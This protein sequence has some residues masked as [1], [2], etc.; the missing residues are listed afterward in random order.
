MLSRV[1]ALWLL[2]KSLDAHKEEVRTR[3]IDSTWLQHIQIRELKKNMYNISKQEFNHLKQLSERDDESHGVYRKDMWST[4][5]SHQQ[6]PVV[7]RSCWDLKI[8][9]SISWSRGDVRSR[10]RWRPRR[11][12]CRKSSATPQLPRPKPWRP[13]RSER[14]RNENHENIEIGTEWHRMSM[15]KQCGNIKSFSNFPTNRT[16]NIQFPVDFLFSESDGVCFSSELKGLCEAALFTILC[17]CSGPKARDGSEF[18]R[19]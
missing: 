18:G 9:E 14:I 8:F 7:L 10:E 11:V 15:W 2:T 12:H 4:K 5:R 17:L 19:A 3:Q 13:K 16:L 6:V 1:Q